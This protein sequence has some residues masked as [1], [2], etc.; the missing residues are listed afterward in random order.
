MTLTTILLP[1]LPCDLDYQLCVCMYI[2]DSYVRIIYYICWP[3]VH[4]GVLGNVV[5]VFN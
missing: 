4:V 1:S 5:E 2:K 3:L